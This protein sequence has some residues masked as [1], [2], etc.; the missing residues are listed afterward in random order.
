ML[1]FEKKSKIIEL[2]TKIRK[3]RQISSLKEVNLYRLN[4]LNRDSLYRFSLVT[5][6]EYNTDIFGGNT[7]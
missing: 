6:E 5:P 3:K 7:K 4:Y 1:K 2:L